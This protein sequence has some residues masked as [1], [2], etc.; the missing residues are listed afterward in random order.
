MI[1]WIIIGI[2]VIAAIGFGAAAASNVTPG[3]VNAGA[4]LF[5]PAILCAAVAILG[6]LLKVAIHFLLQV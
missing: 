2:F 6:I 3:G 4:I 1:L 5:V